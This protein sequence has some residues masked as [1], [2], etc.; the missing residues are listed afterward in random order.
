MPTLKLGM[1]DLFKTFALDKQTA[2][3]VTAFAS[4][5]PFLLIS[6]PKLR[7]RAKSFHSKFR[8]RIANVAGNSDSG[9]NV[10]VGNCCRKIANV[11]RIES[12]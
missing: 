9:V 1:D 8:I 12:L 3:E 7:D 5:S 10:P 6:E 2:A 11:D 4:L